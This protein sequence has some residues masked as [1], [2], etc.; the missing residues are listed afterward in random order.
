MWHYEQSTGHLYDAASKL[1]AVGYSGH[2]DGVNA[3]TLQDVH[4][5]GP[6]P[7]GTYSIGEPEDTPEHGPYVLRLTPA[8]E[9]EMFGRSGFLM[10]GDSVVHPGMASQGC[11]IMPRFAREQVWGSG[12]HNLEVVATFAPVMT[13]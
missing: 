9:N 2:G 5:V 1:L 7:E 8:P 13:A 3:P 6:I 12:D 4:E 10:H 11:I